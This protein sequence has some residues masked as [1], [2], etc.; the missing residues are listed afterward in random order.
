MT[1]HHTRYRLRD[2]RWIAFCE[3][4]GWIRGGLLT[5]RAAI[6][7]GE[8]HEAEELEGALLRELEREGD[9]VVVLEEEGP[10]GLAAFRSMRHV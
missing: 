2:S 4:C 10:V 5:Q 7:A 3:D 1:E 6:A 9:P 8:T